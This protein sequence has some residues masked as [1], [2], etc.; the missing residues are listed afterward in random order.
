MDLSVREVAHLLGVT[1]KTVHRWLREKAIPAHRL[2]DQSRFNRVE[3]QEWAAARGLRLP[4]DLLAPGSK[5]DAALSLREAIE[6]GGIHFHVPGKTAEGVLEAVTNLPGIP[7]GV[8]RSLLRE[9][10]VGREALTSTGIGGGIAIPHPRDPLVM[11]V[12]EPI[13]LACFLEHPVDFRAID[14]APV[15]VLFTLLSPSIRA[16]LQILAKLTY[17]LHDAALSKLLQKPAAPEAILD[18]LAAIESQ[19]RASQP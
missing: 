4:P 18:R 1:E 8:D 6:R 10:L 2:H 7:D 15:R 9:L 16:H 13:V 14:D 3:I 5:P 12:R 17:A 11:Q 19:E